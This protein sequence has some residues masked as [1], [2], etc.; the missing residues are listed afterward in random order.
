M[1]DIQLILFESI[2]KIL[3]QI[4][5]SEAENTSS[6]SDILLW[7]FP[8]ELFNKARDCELTLI[9]LCFMGLPDQ[10]QNRFRQRAHAIAEFNNF[11]G[12]WNEVEELLL[13]HD[14]APGKILSWYLTKHSVQAWFGTDLVRIINIIRSAR[15]YNPYFANKSHV[16]YPERKRGYNDK[17]SLSRVDK[18]T[19]SHWY[20]PKEITEI[21]DLDKHPFY[22]AWY[23]QEKNLMQEDLRV[24]LA[25]PPP[26]EGESDE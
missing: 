16:N 10:Q 13:L 19:L 25:F 8:R 20:T 6:Y 3:S 22:P 24:S 15:T 17:G 14:T 9:A 23:A 5:D 4:K 1:L 26:E 2:N 11:Q 21:P 7:K 18:L 12:K